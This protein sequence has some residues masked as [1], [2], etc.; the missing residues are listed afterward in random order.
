MATPLWADLE[1]I[2]Q[3]YENCPSGFNVDHIIP[4]KG[5]NVCGL[6]VLNNLQYLTPK[7]NLKK[8]NHYSWGE[9]R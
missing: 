2:E 5:K 9:K 1:S 7:D 3:F 6:H 4:L 8:H